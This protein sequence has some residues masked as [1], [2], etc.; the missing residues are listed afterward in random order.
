MKHKVTLIP[1]DGTG[2]EI[3]EATKRVV[4][5]TGVDIEWHI[6]NAG[7]EV[8][9]SEGNV[10][11][12]NVIESLKKD[13]VGIKGPITTPVGTGFRSVNV[14]MRKLFDLYACVRPCKSYKGVRSRYED[15]DLVIIRENTED[16]YAG[17]EFEEGKKET[18]ELIKFIRQIKRVHHQK[19]FGYFYK[20]DICYRVRKDHKVCI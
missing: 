18:G 17:V 8:Y 20:T 6:V 16:L 1:G 5:A 3:T 13:R 12:E 2:P 19:R 9:E 4:E 7:A 14:A 11:P 10:L 15:I